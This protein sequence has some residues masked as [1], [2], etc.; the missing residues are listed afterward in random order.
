MVQL[1][2]RELLAVAREEAARLIAQDP[3]LAAPQHAALAAR[4]ASFLNRVSAE[5]N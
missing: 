5:V 1:S 3:D 4:V 2:D